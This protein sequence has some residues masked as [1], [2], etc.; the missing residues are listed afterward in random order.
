[1]SNRIIKFRYWDP[2][3]S[4]MVFCS[5]EYKDCLS[6]FFIEYDHCQQWGNNPQLMQ[7]T[8]RVD[9]TGKEVF[10]NDI[11]NADGLIAQVIYSDRWSEFKLVGANSLGN[12]DSIKKLGNIHEHKHLLDG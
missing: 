9:D 12:Y 2:I 5:V 4:V 8:G 11:V 6:K 10:E 7:S 3:N 1:M